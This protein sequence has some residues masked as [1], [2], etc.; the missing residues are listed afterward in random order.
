MDLLC[1]LAAGIKAVGYKA[2]TN[3][4]CL[5]TIPILV[6]Q[7]GKRLIL[8]SHARMQINVCLLQTFTSFA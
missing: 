7:W 8:M 5:P 2:D 4:I 6:K 3:V 1:N